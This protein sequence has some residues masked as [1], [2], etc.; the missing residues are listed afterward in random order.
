MDIEIFLLY[1]INLFFLNLF[2]FFIYKK[3]F[4]GQYIWDWFFDWEKCDKF[5]IFF[6]MYTLYIVIITLIAW[7]AYIIDHI[8]H[9]GN[10]RRAWRYFLFYNYFLLT[11]FW[12]ITYRNIKWLVHFFKNPHFLYGYTFFEFWITDAVDWIEKNDLFFSNLFYDWD[13]IFHYIFDSVYDSYNIISE[14][15][16]ILE[17][18]L[19]LGSNRSQKISKKE[20]NKY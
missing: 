15:F 3:N 18:D 12:L 8:I 13:I 14:V 19:W 5:D 2:Y 9:I 20:K 4:M 7:L 6:K 1:I 17:N 11:Q 16:S 10:Y